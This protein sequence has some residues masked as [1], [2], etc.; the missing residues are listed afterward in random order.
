[1]EKKKWYYCAACPFDAERIL[2][3][4]ATN[5][6]TA[7]KVFRN[8]ELLNTALKYLNTTLTT[9]YLQIFKHLPLNAVLDVV[10]FHIWIVFHLDCDLNQFCHH[11]N[12][13]VGYVKYVDRTVCYCVYACIFA[14]VAK[15]C[16][17]ITLIAFPLVGA[18]Y[19][20]IR[21]VVHIGFKFW[22][23]LFWRFC[24]IDQN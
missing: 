20:K 16:L 23:L 6:K 19:W 8:F 14:A 18:K 17:R 4:Q 2:N 12:W 9:C 5:V 21:V 7:A 3:L 1:M 11:Y 15:W 10:L 24:Q 22:T 13:T